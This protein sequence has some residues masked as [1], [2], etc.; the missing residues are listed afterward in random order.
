MILRGGDDPD[1]GKHNTFP[2]M[3]SDGGITKPGVGLSIVPTL[4]V[5]DIA[6][7]I[8]LIH[9]VIGFVWISLMPPIADIP[10]KYYNK[11]SQKPSL[12]HVSCGQD[13]VLNRKF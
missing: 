6:D 7:I 3:R 11:M 9:G 13:R 5:D 10:S 12:L 8:A 4:D 1:I 2:S